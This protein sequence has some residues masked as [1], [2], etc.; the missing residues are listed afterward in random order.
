MSS[1]A[2]LFWPGPI[3]VPHWLLKFRKG[4]FLGLQGRAFAEAENSSEPGVCSRSPASSSTHS[5]AVWNIIVCPYLRPTM[6]IITAKIG[7]CRS[8][9]E[10]CPARILYAFR[11]PWPFS[12]TPVICDRQLGHAQSNLAKLQAKSIRKEQHILWHAFLPLVD[13]IQT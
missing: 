12:K 7:Q 1:I 5:Y 6:A 2:R 3:S 9:T 4:V 11:C 13:W 8:F 10:S